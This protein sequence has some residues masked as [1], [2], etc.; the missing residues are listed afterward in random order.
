MVEEIVRYPMKKNTECPMFNFLVKSNSEMEYW[1]F[2]E[3]QDAYDCAKSLFAKL[4]EMILIYEYH[5]NTVT[6]EYKA[7][8]AFWTD[9]DG[10]LKYVPRGDIELHLEFYINAGEWMNPRQDW[11]DTLRRYGNE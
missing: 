4:D 6:R 8:R 1:L 9:I 2:D 10:K 11:I 3:F 5:L 7:R